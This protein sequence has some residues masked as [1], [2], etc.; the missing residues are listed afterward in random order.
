MDKDL[1]TIVILHKDRTSKLLKTLSYLERENCDHNIFISDGSIKKTEIDYKKLKLRIKHQYFGEDINLKIFMKK[2]FNTLKRIK[3]KYFLFLDE[4][5]FIDLKFI[6]NNLYILKKNK[7]VSIGGKILN[8]FDQESKSKISYISGSYNYEHKN[9]IKRLDKYFNN[10]QLL[11][12]N[13][14]NTRSLTTVFKKISSLK[15]LSDPEFLEY[16]I[17]VLIISEGDILFIDKVF[18]YKRAPFQSSHNFNK[19]LLIDNIQKR[20]W[21]SFYNDMLNLIF[22]RFDI[23]NEKDKEHYQNLFFGLFCNK[24]IYDMISRY[25]LNFK[26]VASYVK[27]Y[28]VLNSDVKVLQ[29]IYRNFKSLKYSLKFKKNINFLKKRIAKFY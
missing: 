23:K 24:L 7:Y 18:Y 10:R 16:L 19:R 11:Y 4:D 17:D 2:V 26:N 28:V 13:I 5:D 12:Y 25:N 3:T 27:R 21:S 20:E 15:E 1:L 6:E 14:Q 22:D 9:K 8:F 29:T